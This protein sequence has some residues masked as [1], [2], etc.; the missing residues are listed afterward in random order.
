MM[1]KGSL[2]LLEGKGREG[3][4]WFGEKGENFKMLNI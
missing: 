2:A 4:E 1:E 3:S